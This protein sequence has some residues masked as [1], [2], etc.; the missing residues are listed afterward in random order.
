MSENQPYMLNGIESI[1]YYSTISALKTN[2]KRNANSIF[3]E[4]EVRCPE[5][6]ISNMRVFS[7][8]PV[9][10]C[11]LKN[12]TCTWLQNAIAQCIKLMIA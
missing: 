7:S 9:Y 8:Y 6:R 2:M 5:Y 12:T 1:K 4:V 3:I 10:N 11:R